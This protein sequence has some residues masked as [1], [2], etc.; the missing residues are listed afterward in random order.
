MIDNQQVSKYYKIKVQFTADP[1]VLYAV[2]ELIDNSEDAPIST[3]GIPV[4]ASLW[5]THWFAIRDP[6]STGI[7]SSLLIQ[8]HSKYNRQ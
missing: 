2:H 1:N 8:K 7:H 4:K 6:S 3:K 5:C